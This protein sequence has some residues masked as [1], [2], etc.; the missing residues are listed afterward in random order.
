MTIN[1]HINET[2]FSHHFQP[3]IYLPRQQYIGYEALY[4]S[5][6]YPNPEC[7]FAAAKQVHRLFDLDTA[8]MQK[9]IQVFAAAQHVK[10]Q[11]LFI[12]AYPSTLLDDRFLTFIQ[13]TIQQAK[14]EPE[15]LVIEISEA[16][17]INSPT[18]FQRIKLLKQ[19]GFSIALDDVGKGYANFNALINIEA[20]FIKLD[21]LFSAQLHN[22]ERKQALLRLFH[23]FCESQGMQL[24]LEGIETE[25]EYLAARKLN[26]A[27]GQGFYLGRPDT[28]TN[29]E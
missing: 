6:A 29:S 27:F 8:S 7:A 22:H 10:D 9:A 17:Q 15:Q 19:F 3:I 4:R 23:S 28:F 14:L 20:D 13:Q 24:I 21:R 26:V 18:F 16:E 11:R 2:S 1:Q 5:S 12:N 25:Q